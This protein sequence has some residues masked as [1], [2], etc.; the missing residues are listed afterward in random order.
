MFCLD[1]LADLRPECV[2]LA[3]ELEELHK[4][5]E[6][7]EQVRHYQRLAEFLSD[8]NKRIDGMR[9]EVEVGRRLIFL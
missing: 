9:E 5:T 8:E 2:A 7:L 1:R 3:K 6:V 4:Q